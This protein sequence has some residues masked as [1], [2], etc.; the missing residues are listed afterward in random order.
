MPQDQAVSSETAAEPLERLRAHR[1]RNLTMGGAERVDRHHASGRLTV[2][3]RIDLLLDRGSWFELGL[4]ADAQL[5]RE[6]PVPA[7]AMVTGW[8]RVNGCRVCV[9]GI[10]ATVLAGTTA[11]LNMLKQ[12]RLIAF[13]GRRGLPVIALS[14]A[15][16]GRIPDVMGWRFSGLPFDFATFLQA[17]HGHPE[18]LRITA[19]L[20]PSY[21]D[22]ALHAAAAHF[23]VMTRG[24]ALALSG[25]SVIGSAVGEIVSDEDL[26][27][28]DAVRETGAAHL[29]VETEH[30]ALEAIR[31]L[32]TYLPPNAGRPAPE[33]PSRMPS[34][35]PETLLKTVP[36]ERKRA[37]DMRRVIDAIVDADSSFELRPD[38]AKSLI[39]T[40]ARIEG[41]PVGLIA[42]QPLFKGGVLDDRALAKEF[43]FV[44]L[45]D[46][47]NIPLVFLHD[48]P[49]L[50]I[51]SQAERAG[52][53]AWYERVVGRIARAKVPK[54]GVV[55]RKSYGGGHF[56]MGGRPTHPDLLVCWPGAELGFMA[57]ETGVSTVHR[58]TLEDIEASQG[59]QAREAE[60]ARL[61]AEWTD[62]SAPW[63]AASHLYVD[64]IIEPGETRE[65][66]A[67][68][69]EFGWGDRR[70][71]G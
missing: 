31:R 21:G 13:A 45:C 20:G 64:D 53:L 36:A 71:P 15:D 29:I 62:E 55:V 61:T 40:L 56:A 70:L 32:L 58:R 30:E 59:R 17:P 68:G 44:D 25:P 24:A 46:T 12:N 9:L 2:R 23:V 39:T 5:R 69:I 1:R 22:A 67:R 51:G 37:Y 18:V 8:G 10:D 42:S 54:V 3:E 65:V 63:E 47:F 14:D 48:V 43:S 60:I 35:G 7:D 38:S 6:T 28:V 50:M 19:I 34:R 49:G 27:G 33:A 41:H 26:G 66:V 4:L 11:P 52:I 16:G 57:P